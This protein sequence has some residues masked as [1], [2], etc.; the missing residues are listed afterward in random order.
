MIVVWYNGVRAAARR[1]QRIRAAGTER[2]PSLQVRQV[3]RRGAVASAVG[4][5][6][7]REQRGVCSS[8]HRSP[9]AEPPARWDRGAAEH[10]NHARHRGGYEAP[11]CGRVSAGVHFQRVGACASGAVANL[12]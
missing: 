10:L 6:D 1:C 5:A 2:K 7:N 11:R 12:E 3:E 4:G 9:V 8:A